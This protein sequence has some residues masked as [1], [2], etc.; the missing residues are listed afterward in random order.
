[1]FSKSDPRVF[2]SF[3][4][5]T[6]LVFLGDSTPTNTRSKLAAC[7]KPRISYFV[8]R[9]IVASH[10]KLIGKLF[11]LPNLISSSSNSLVYL[12]L[13]MKLASVN[14]TEPT[15]SSYSFCTSAKTCLTDLLLG[16]LPS[17]MIMSQNSQVNGQPR[18]VC[19]ENSKYGLISKQARLKRLFIIQTQYLINRLNR[20]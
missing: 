14:T 15:P 20:I 8:A 16:T 5:S 9:F 6:R 4:V 12:G 10:A 7:I 13:P 3:F 2:T 11:S 18:V 17:V 1:M 19:I